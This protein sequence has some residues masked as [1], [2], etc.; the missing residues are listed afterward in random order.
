V[1]RSSPAG[2]ARGRV[3]SI[4]IGT[5][6]VLLLVVDPV[7]GTE[8]VLVDRSVVTRLGRGVDSTRHL[9]E[10]A[11]RRT[12]ACL[13]VFA[14]ELNAL[15]VSRRVV[16][17]TSALRDAQGT[18]DFLDEAE[19]I[20]GVRPSILGGNEEA[21]LTF[22]G[23]VSG[24]NWAGTATVFDVGGGSTEF[25]A[26]QVS[27]GLTCISSTC[28]INVGSVRMHERHVSHD[29]PLPTELHAIRQDIRG[30]LP[31]SLPYRNARGVIGVAG[32]IT[33]LFAVSVAMTH[34]DG[35]RVHGRCLSREQISH[36][37]ELFARLSVAERRK[38]PGLE[39]R[40]ADVIGTGTLIVLEVMDW[41][42]ISSLIVSDR[43]VR[44]GLMQQA[45]VNQ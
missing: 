37:S 33:T 42:Q 45:A 3:A 21:Q 18:N 20:L 9:D 32:T 38:I 11:A 43:G 16:V 7:E 14:D 34:Y 13:E 23:A 15:N 22:C 4:D 40:R 44:W 25:I 27:E 36:W 39:A 10:G 6:S 5:N 2:P 26:G 24:L 12:L 19:R 29:P 41:L 8:R 30:Q 1:T 28:S 35:A 17:G 31:E